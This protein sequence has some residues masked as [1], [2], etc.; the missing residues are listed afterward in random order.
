MIEPSFTGLMIFVG[1]AFYINH[2]IIYKRH[3]FMGNIVNII[4]SISILMTTE[5]SFVVMVGVV[6]A[7]VFFIITVIDLLNGNR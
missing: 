4:I 3:R 6:F 2:L 5:D 7:I 1:I